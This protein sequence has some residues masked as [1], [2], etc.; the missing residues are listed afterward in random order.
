MEVSSTDGPCARRELDADPYQNSG[1]SNIGGHS[2]S[3]VADYGHIQETCSVDPSDTYF[4]EEMIVQAVANRAHTSINR[5]D[6]VK[7]FAASFAIYVRK[8]RPRDCE[9]KIS[10]LKEGSGETRDVVVVDL[11]LIIDHQWQI[12]RNAQLDAVW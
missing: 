5:R 1:A 8:G 3:E 12:L 4:G 11:E 9:K 7:V 2:G 10:A 6:V